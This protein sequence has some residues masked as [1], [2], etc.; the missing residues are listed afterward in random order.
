MV[1]RTLVMVKTMKMITVLVTLFVAG[2]LSWAQSSRYGEN[3]S[4]ASE[5]AD[6]LYRLYCGS[7]HSVD[8][9]NWTP[10]IDVGEPK[11]IADNCYLIHDG[12]HGYFLW[13][14]GVPDDLTSKPNGVKVNQVLTWKRDN[15]RNPTLMGQLAEIH[16]SPSDIQ[17]I[18]LSHANG[19]RIGN[20]ELFPQVTLIMAKAEANTYFGPRGAA[21]NPNAERG[22]SDWIISKT[23]PMMTIDEDLDV[24]KDGNLIMFATPGHAPGHEALLVHLKKTGWIILAG[25]AVM[26][27]YSNFDNR[28]VPTING[29]EPDVSIKKLQYLVSMDRIAALMSFY[30][31][32][33]WIGYD[34]AQSEKQKLSPD[35]YE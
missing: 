8:G 23:H 35:F 6:R 34:K 11:D 27:F 32:Q 16:V 17:F 25:D 31:A 1:S 28:R 5:G 3:Q 15:M 2:S 10:G 20:V 22:D 21:N 24:F 4:A 12:S 7:G 29:S 26:S 19:D 9:S 18:G 13:D 14:T 30:R 33:L